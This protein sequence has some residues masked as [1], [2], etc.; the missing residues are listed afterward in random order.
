[1]NPDRTQ[2]GTEAPMTEDTDAKER[3]TPSSDFVLL[4]EST[5]PDLLRDR[6]LPMMVQADLRKA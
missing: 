3:M 5:N 4:A 1:M 2:L 6:A